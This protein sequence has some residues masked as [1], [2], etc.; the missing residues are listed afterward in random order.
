MSRLIVTK[1]NTEVK[2]DK[3][4]YIIN[5]YSLSLKIPEAGGI[6]R[7]GSRAQNQHMHPSSPERSECQRCTWYRKHPDTQCHEQTPKG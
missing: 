5:N 3:D 6:K 7:S 4:I 2:H 1:E